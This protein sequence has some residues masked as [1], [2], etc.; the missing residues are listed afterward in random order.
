MKMEIVQET[1]LKLKEAY[2]DISGE[3]ARRITMIMMDEFSEEKIHDFFGMMGP[4]QT[5]QLVE[6]A[7]TLLGVK[8][9]K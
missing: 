1:S 7:M 4:E 5:M 2:G 9:K 8:P 3:E 6:R